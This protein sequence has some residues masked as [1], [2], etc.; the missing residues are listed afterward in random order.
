MINR[1]DMMELT[2]RMTPS[3]SSMTRIAGSYMDEEGYID[4]TFNVNFLKLKPKDK[5]KNLA[6]A[7]AIPFSETNTELK[8]YPFSPEA[9]KP[10]GVWQL[11]MGM[12]SCGLKNDALMDTFYD[13]VSE[14]YPAGHAY[15]VY[16]FHDRYDV[17][18]K[19]ADHERVG[20][21]EE[22]FEYMICAICPVTEDYEPGKP[23]CG[24]IFPAFSERSADLQHVDVFHAKERH[25]EVM[26][27]L[28][29][30]Q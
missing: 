11:L 12:K 7:K 2:R 30:Q 22:V 13:I 28:G 5:E 27:M 17:P 26:N 14:K 10:G 16:V 3:R 29:E 18:V 24:F 25:W 19:A 4:G 21:S 1:E 20:E 23:E 8:R 6:I 9:R 15:G